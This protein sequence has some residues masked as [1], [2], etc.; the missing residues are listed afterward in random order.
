MPAEPPKTA[1][2]RNRYIWLATCLGVG[3]GALTL[4]LLLPASRETG[5]LHPL[6]WQPHHALARPWT[7][8][9][10]AWI[11]LSWAHLVGNLLALGALAVLGHSIRAGTAAAVALLVAWPLATA[12]LWLWPQ[13]SG[14]AGLSALIHAAALVLIAQAA[15]YSIA[16]PLSFV[17]LAGMGLKL[18]TER[19]WQ[20]PVVFDPSWG[21]N[22]VLASHLGGALAGA[23]SGWV[24]VGLARL[25]KRS[26]VGGAASKVV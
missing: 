4:A 13:V 24:V 21:F 26:G 7:L 9:T 12:S 23:V 11:H 3:V 6:A 18:L 8:W 1:R 17:L 15:I 2:T 22:V 25:I 16:K 5:A 10:A 20:H 19:A 14:Y